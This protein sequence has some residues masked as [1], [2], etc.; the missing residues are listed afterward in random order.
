MSNERE[1]LVSVL[2]ALRN[3][4]CHHMMGGIIQELI[5]NDACLNKEERELFIF[6]YKGMIND[7]RFSIHTIR[8]E[9]AKNT[10]DEHA[11]LKLNQLKSRIFQEMSSIS[12]EI[13]GVI[14]SK[15]IP[16]N[17]DPKAKICF[18]KFKAD[19]Y[20][21]LWESCDMKEKGHLVTKAADCYNA[22]LAVA[23]ENVPKRDPTSLGLQLNYA[24]FLFE[25]SGQRE[26]AVELLDTTFNE[27]CRP[28]DED[29]SD[30]DRS[31]THIL[32]QMM[33]DNI[34]LWNKILSEEKLAT[35]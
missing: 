4:K 5:H 6:A 26:Q 32:L 21:Y 15:L 3:A 13:T 33:R 19:M 20:R 31:H 8:E 1:G 16:K 35:D 22:A 29:L 34:T 30:S 10:C 24:V 27:C 23:Q 28:T 2:K 17:D 7:K 9:I 12:S 14:D 11:V 18:L 25:V